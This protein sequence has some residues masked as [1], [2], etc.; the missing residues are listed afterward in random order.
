MS[1]GM[2]RIPDRD[3]EFAVRRTLG[4]GVSYWETRD[5]IRKFMCNLLDPDTHGATLDVLG[6]L[7]DPSLSDRIPMV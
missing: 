6:F 1:K 4:D 7:P 2:V 5:A 3:L